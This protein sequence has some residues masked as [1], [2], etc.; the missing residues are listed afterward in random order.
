MT[1]RL[2]TTI[3]MTIALA[4]G[5]V[6]IPV[7]DADP[8]PPQQGGGCDMVFGPLFHSPNSNGLTNMMSGSAGSTDGVGAANMQEMLSRFGC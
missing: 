4:G 2:L 3:S 8:G 6:A 7:A 1:K 5:A